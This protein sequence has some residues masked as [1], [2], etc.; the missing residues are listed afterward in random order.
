VPTNASVRRSLLS[1]AYLLSGACFAAHPLATEDTGTQGTGALEME[2]GL[3]RARVPATRVDEL[4][5]QLSYGVLDNLDLILRP[6]YVQVRADADE[7]TSR[8]RGFGDASVG[9]KWR[10]TQAGPASLGTRMDVLGPTG[11]ADRGLGAGGPTYRALLIG[12][13]EQ[14]AWAW[15]GNLGYIRVPSGPEVRQN[16]GYASVATVWSPSE[17]I[18]LSLELIGTSNPL[19]DASRALVSARGGIF[20][21]LTDRYKVDVGYDRRINGGY[22]TSTTLLGATVRF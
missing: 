13:V 22:R 6:T 4:G 16:L 20:V 19:T 17:R 3:Q 18:R 12:S 11:D 21:N 7:T 2:V 14:G 10:F 8:S 5:V 9:F 1:T 15:H